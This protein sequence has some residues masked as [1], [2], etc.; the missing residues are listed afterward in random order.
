M[1]MSTFTIAEVGVNH[2][3]STEMAH[4]LIGASVKAG[5]DAVKFQTFQAESLIV[6]GTEAVSYQK[7]Q[8]GEDDQ[9][10]LLRKLELS[11]AEYR[12]LAAACARQGIEFMSTAFDRHSL[13]FLVEIGLRR[14]KIPSGEVTNIP[15]LQNA[16]SHGL[17]VLLSTGMATLAEVRTAVEVVRGVQSRE[18]ADDGTPMLTVLHCTSA[19]PA[20]FEHIN[21]KALETLARELDMPVG[22]SDHSSGILIAPVAVALGAVVIEK[23]ITLDRTLKG[24]DHAASIE[25]DDF[26][27]MVRN[28]GLVEKALGDGIK[29]PSGPEIET[30][31]LVR[32]GL[33][34]ASSLPG[35]HRLRRED[36]AILRPETGL[37]PGRLEDAIGRRLVRALGA[38]E[39]IQEQDLD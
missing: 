29:K 17:P 24:P 36:I 27:R 8:A 33:K 38:G 31:R 18:R 16:A 9:Y 19:Y 37:A 32:R 26:T 1:C 6:P 5:A 21:L 10:R 28:I 7:Q 25:P 39:P 3:G 22:Y 35:G 13:E 30:A 11:H 2:N 12:E 15:F 23:H 20:Q 4:A 14:V 34:A